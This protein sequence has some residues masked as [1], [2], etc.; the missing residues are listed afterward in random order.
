M[1]RSMCITRSHTIRC[2]L[3]VAV[4]CECMHTVSSQAVLSSHYTKEWKERNMTQ[5]CLLTSNWS[6]RLREEGL[7]LPCVW[8]FHR[9]S[10]NA[11]QTRVL[12]LCLTGC[13]TNGSP[14]GAD[15]AT[16]DLGFKEGFLLA[17]T[18]NSRGLLMFISDKLG[19]FLMLRLHL[20][21]LER[22]RED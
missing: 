17:H 4:K 19:N 20:L 14:S 6:P 3:I 21:K 1:T 9:A 22:Y 2:V 12:R 13:D 16:R 10:I 5:R 8:R 11:R 15:H 7:Q 18:R